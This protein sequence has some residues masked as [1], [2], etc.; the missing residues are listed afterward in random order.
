MTAAYSPMKI[1]IPKV[2]I[3]YPRR[4]TVVRNSKVATVFVLRHRLISGLGDD[5]QKDVFHRCE[6]RLEAVYVSP[7]DDE[8]SEKVRRFDASGGRNPPLPVGS[9]Y[10]VGGLGDCRECAAHAHA[11]L[12]TRMTAPDIVH[13]AVHHEPSAMDQRHAI[14]E[15]FRLAHLVR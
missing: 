11:Y 9:W 6:H 4:L 10:C 13:A 14:A 15:H 5:A 2:A 3:R 8:R 7:C 12:R 1:G